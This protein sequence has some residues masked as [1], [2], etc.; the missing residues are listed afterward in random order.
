VPEPHGSS[1]RRRSAQS[2]G[3][4]RELAILD[5]AERQLTE[6]GVDR[7][8]VET[9]AVGAGITRGAFYF[10]FGGKNAVLAAVVDRTAARVVAEVERAEASAPSDPREA[11]C[12]A[13]FQTGRLWQ[14]CGI[15]MRAAVELSSSVPEVD[16]AWQSAIA[17]T[18]TATRR[19]LVRAGVPDDD[20][21]TGAAAYSE[22]MVLMTERTFYWASKRG[23]PLEETALTVAGLWLAILPS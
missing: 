4:L 17:A 19:A 3:D 8:T 1:L 23:L 7:M 21:P 11:L 5:A 15:V 12:E 20:G 10:Y 22:A 13:V 9:I 18:N 2:K 14:E 16:R 6:D